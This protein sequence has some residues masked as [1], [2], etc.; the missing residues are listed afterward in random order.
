[1]ILPKV[2]V[3]VSAH[4]GTQFLVVTKEQGVEEG[5]LQWTLDD[6]FEV[7]HVQLA[8]EAPV[9]GLGEELRQDLQNGLGVVDQNSGPILDPADDV[10]QPLPMT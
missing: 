7:P 5:T 1:M 4:S 10:F 9:L 3:D 2:V 6:P 8:L